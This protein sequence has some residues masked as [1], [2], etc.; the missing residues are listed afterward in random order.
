MRTSSNR[1]RNQIMSQPSIYSMLA[2]RQLAAMERRLT[3]APRQLMGD[4][5]AVVACLLRRPCP[6]DDAAPLEMFFILRAKR[7]GR[8]SGQVGFPGG[9]AD[10]G[11][12]DLQAVERECTEECGLHLSSP[13]AYRRLGELPQL[14]VDRTGDRSLIVC[15]Y[16]FEQLQR[17]PHT[18]LQPD[19]VSET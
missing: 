8:W 18:R 4:A 5:R 15:C 13:G 11:E 3:T 17:E 16:V 10:A 19:E 2:A 1:F 6:V 14:R 9:H 7:G 12:T